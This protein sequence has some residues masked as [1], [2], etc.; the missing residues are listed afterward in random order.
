MCVSYLEARLTLMAAPRIQRLDKSPAT[1]ALKDIRRN[2]ESIY[3]LI[4]GNGQTN[5]FLKINFVFQ[6][7]FS[8]YLIVYLT[9]HKIASSVN[10][11]EMLLQGDA[12]CSKVLKIKGCKRNQ[13]S[14][15]NLNKFQETSLQN[16]PFFFKFLG[17]LIST[18][19]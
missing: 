18:S 6:K 17:P 3:E 19:F 9:R 8:N 10:R 7:Q 14:F 12:V 4:R 2:K 13:L 15:L 1:I 16:W 11:K 5:N